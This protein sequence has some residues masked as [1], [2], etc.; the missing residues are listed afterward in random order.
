MFEV[1][2]C[3]KTPHLRGNGTIQ[4]VQFGIAL[5]DAKG[6]LVHFR[7]EAAAPHAQQEDMGKPG[8]FYF[9]GKRLQPRDVTDLLFRKGQPTEGV[10]NDGLMGGVLMPECGIFRPNPADKIL[11]L[12]IVE[13]CTHGLVE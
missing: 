9:I 3:F 12:Q 5:D 2:S 8:I 6:H 4:H 13:C 10:S 7:A 11:G 1:D